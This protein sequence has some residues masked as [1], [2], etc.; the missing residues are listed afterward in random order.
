[1]AR[2]IVNASLTLDGVMQAPGR[3]DEDTRGGFTHGGWATTYFHPMMAPD[4]SGGT[5]ALPGLLFGRRTYEDFYKV[6]PPQKGN[7][8]T[9]LMNSS[10]KFVASRTLREPLPWMNSTLLPGEAADSVAALKAGS[11]RDLVILGSGVLVQ[12]LL[13]HGLVDEFMLSIHPLVLGTGRRLFPDQGPY[14]R[15]RLASSKVTPTGVVIA[16]YQ[17]E[18]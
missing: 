7:F 4:M 17:P 1:M 10:P 14:A 18:F 16:T 12:S 13:A 3:P 15:L 2:L 11:D 5:A 6:W 8:F 9:E